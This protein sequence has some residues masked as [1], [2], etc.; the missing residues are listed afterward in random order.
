[1]PAIYPRDL[2][3]DSEGTW[4]ERIVVFESR[5]LLSYWQ[6]EAVKDEVAREEVREM[7]AILGRLLTQMAIICL[8]EEPLLIVDI[9]IGCR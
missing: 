2:V 1:M 4:G 7:I 3:L 9:C 5:Q 8:I 6:S